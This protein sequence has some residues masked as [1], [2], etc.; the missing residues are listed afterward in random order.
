MRAKLA[1]GAAPSKSPRHASDTL[2]ARSW[3]IRRCR[4]AKGTRK[5]LTIGVPGIYV[6]SAVLHYREEWHKSSRSTCREAG[7]HVVAY[8][9][10]YISIFAVF[11]YEFIASSRGGDHQQEGGVPGMCSATESSGKW[12]SRARQRSSNVSGKAAI[13]AIVASNHKREG[14]GRKMNAPRQPQLLIAGS[15]CS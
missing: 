7:D 4:R 8:I 10:R 12:A 5:D 3:T 6:I 15:G 11:V 2:L 9:E 14:I 1:T 13:A